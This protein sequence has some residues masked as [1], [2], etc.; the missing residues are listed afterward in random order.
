M[1]QVAQARLKA[2][3][4]DRTKGQQNFSLEFD[5]ALIAQVESG[6]AR[7]G[8]ILPH[9][10]ALTTIDLTSLKIGSRWASLTG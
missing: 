8:D 9:V 7:W 10:K 1:P 2:R 6:G 5:L 3:N 4:I